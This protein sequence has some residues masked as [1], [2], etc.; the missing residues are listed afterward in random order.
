MRYSLRRSIVTSANSYQ[1][2]CG[3]WRVVPVTSPL[4]LSSSSALRQRE[5]RPLV[6][7][8]HWEAVTKDPFGIF[9]PGLEVPIASRSKLNAML[10]YHG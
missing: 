9:Q 6:K 7:M 3:G 4:G 10:K 8:R 1:E 5:R 2:G